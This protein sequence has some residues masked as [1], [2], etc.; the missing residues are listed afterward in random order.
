MSTQHRMSPIAELRGIIIL[1]V[2]FLCVFAYESG[3]FGFGTLPTDHLE[4]AYGGHGDP[5]F[6]KERC[7]IEYVAPWC[8]ACRAS[9]GF[10]NA[11]HRKLTASSKVGMKIVVGMSDRENLREMAD[12]YDAPAFLDVDGAFRDA[13]GIHSVPSAL[14]IDGNRT[15]IK[16][17][18]SGAIGGKASEE[19]NVQY[20]ID[21]YLD[22]ASFFRNG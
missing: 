16:K 2:V 9:I 6:G 21:N 19:E 11:L 8:P 14:V 20:Y 4:A 13:L 18:L 1:V 7:V 22:I 5:C 10:S 17:G 3:V 12:K 15:I